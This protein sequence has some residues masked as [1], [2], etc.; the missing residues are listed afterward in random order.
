[1]HVVKAAAASRK[2]AV[3]NSAAETELGCEFLAT[4]ECGCCRKSEGSQLG[5]G[6]KEENLSG[7]GQ[8]WWKL[9]PT[10]PELLCQR[11]SRPRGDSKS[12]SILR[13]YRCS[14]FKNT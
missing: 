4:E 9:V 1:M 3:S 10:K 13:L 14:I 2:Q 12:Y 8:Q 11:S 5:G 6:K 7:G